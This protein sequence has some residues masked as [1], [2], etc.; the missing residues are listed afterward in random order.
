MKKFLSL[1]LMLAFCILF[2]ACSPRDQ[3][4]TQSVVVQ[5]VTDGTKVSSVV[6]KTIETCPKTEKKGFL[7]EG[8]YKNQDYTGGRIVFPF[9]AE[10][11]CKLYAKWIDKEKGNEELVYRELDDRTLKVTFCDTTCPTVWIPDKKDGKDVTALDAGFL[12]KTTYLTLLHIGKNVKTIEETFYLCLALKEI[13]TDEENEY[14][15]SVDGVLCSHDKTL[16]YAYPTAKEDEAF[17]MPSSVTELGVNAFTYN[18]F[19]KELR[20]NKKLVTSSTRFRNMESLQKFFVEEGNESFSSENGVLYSSDGKSLL[21]F[22]A[23]F[24]S[25]SFSV[26]AGT[27]EIKENAFYKCNLTS[28][29]IN[30]ELSVFNAPASAPELTEYTVEEGNA[31]FVSRD[32]VLFTDEGKTLYRMPLGR[33][34]E[35][36][37]PSGTETVYDFAFTKSAVQKVSFPAS[38]TEIGHFAFSE[39]VYLT[40]VSFAEGSKLEKIEDSAFSRC[41]ALKKLVLTSRVPPQTES[42]VF[43]SCMTGFT[44]VIPAYTGGLYEALWP[45]CADSFSAT[46]PAAELFEI[47]FDSQGGSAV[48]KV[49]GAYCLEEPQVTRDA[50]SAGEYYVFLGWYDNPE[51]TGKKISFPYAI[52]EDITLYAA[53]DIGFYTDP[54]HTDS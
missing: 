2:T 43:D 15:T 10:S 27:E 24:P 37:A 35:Y 3:E 1:F 9:R 53:W 50:E 49:R 19:L 42:G 7:L 8:W 17:F 39:C 34:G 12:K 52:E 26:A 23:C 11:S 45:F 28:L 48:A 32:G 20:L 47:V 14:W 46:G 21:V 33:S 22:P 4:G 25:K 13:E 18:L 30:K 51:G 36:V 41:F 54:D 31:Y 6:D 16:L 44:V 38:V 40:E 5:F 29:N